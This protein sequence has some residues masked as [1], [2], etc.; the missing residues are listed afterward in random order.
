MYAGGSQAKTPRAHLRR[1]EL[2]ARG[3]WEDDPIADAA[4]KSAIETLAER[5]TRFTI[6]PRLPDEHGAERVRDAI[7]KKMAHLP[8]LMLN[9]LTWDQGS[10][11]A[12][13][14]KIGAALGM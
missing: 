9:S 4:N 2:H 14:K 12:R 6:P 10:E 5:A 3:R 8:E 1:H 11:L 13:H 7:V